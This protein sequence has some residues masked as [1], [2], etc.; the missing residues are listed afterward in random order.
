MVT[1]IVLPTAVMSNWIRSTD[2]ETRVIVVVEDPDEIK[3]ILGKPVKIGRSPLMPPS[4]ML[5]PTTLER[6]PG[7]AMAPRVD[8]R[9]VIDLDGGRLR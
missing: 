8:P 1:P 2:A 4:R 3:R 7:E 6:G 9:R 5:G